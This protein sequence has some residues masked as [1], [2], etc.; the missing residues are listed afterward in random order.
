MKLKLTATAVKNLKTPGLH[1]DGGGL[2]VRVT[3]SGTK[4]WIFR[5]RDRTTG[6]LRDMG[7]GSAED[8]SLKEAREAATETRK[9]VAGGFDP[10]AERNRERAARRAQ[11]ANMLTF[12]QCADR[13]ITTHEPSWKNPKHVQQWRNT[14]RD[15]AAPVIGD[16]PVNMV[17]D[18]HVLAILEPIWHA[19]TETASRV[20]SRL[21]RILDWATAHKYR[22]GANPARWKG[23]LA[24]MLPSPSKIKKV[25]HHPSLPYA[26]IYGFVQEIRGYT[27]IAAR[28]LEFTILTAARTEESTGTQWSEVDFEARIWTVP[29]E[30]MKGGI[31]HRVP[32]SKAAIDLLKDQHGQ[33]NTFVFPG[34][35]D[36]KHLSDAAMMELVKDLKTQYKDKDG[37]RITVHGFRSTFRNWSAEQTNFPR[38][39]CEASMAHKLKDKTEAAYFTSDVLEKRAALIGQWAT[40]CNTK[41]KKKATVTSI[42]TSAS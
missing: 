20:R 16:L 23:H 41:L 37:R 39:V 27:G 3:K 35:Q 29:G 8:F 5:W 1:N 38:E 11:A 4:S 7:L 32:L 36:G 18:H 19:K 24:A 12:D 28:C 13:Y 6:N 10:I 9:L 34:L 31:E 42:Q 2:Y 30:R 33:H 17:A 21:E 40:Y 14:L 26:E 15:Y 22:D 25:Q